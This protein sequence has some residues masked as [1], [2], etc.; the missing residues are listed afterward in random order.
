MGNQAVRIFFERGREGIMH[1]TSRISLAAGSCVFRRLWRA[2]VSSGG[3]LDC[4]LGDLPAKLPHSLVKDFDSSGKPKPLFLSAPCAVHCCTKSSQRSTLL[5]RL[6]SNITWQESTYLV[7]SAFSA[8][9]TWCQKSH[10]PLSEEDK[11]VSLTCLRAPDDAPSYFWNSGQVVS[12][13]N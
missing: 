10:P 3:I 2:S 4:T 5:R 9:Y 11:T 12:L 8:F 6:L 1:L 13:V 7:P